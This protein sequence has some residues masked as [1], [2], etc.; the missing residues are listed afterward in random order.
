[1][2]R[3]EAAIFPGQLAE[4]VGMGRTLAATSPAAAAVLA[5][6][7][8][9]LGRQLGA[10]LRRV[11]FEGPPER[12]ATPFFAQTGVVV[13][14]LMSYAA[15]E[16]AEVEVGATAGY[17]LGVLAALAAAEALTLGEVLTV[18]DR[19]IASYDHHLGHFDG[20][21]AAVTGLGEA[22]LRELAALA[23]RPDDSVEIGNFNNGHQFVLTGS[24][25]A[26]LRAIE[27]A[28]PTALGVRLL[29]ITWPVHSVYFEPVAREL[30]AELPAL[31]RP[32]RPR[33][34]VYS[35]ITG[36]PVGD[37]HEVL[38]L[39]ATEIARPVR[40]HQV[41][42]AM[43]RDGHLHF[44]ECGPSSDLARMVRWIDRR[45]VVRSMGEG[46]RHEEVAV[47]GDR[48]GG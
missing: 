23:S 10:E 33:M 1:M 44:T 43:R 11:L 25:A 27:L 41:I 9:E 47:R 39:V 21:M 37:E 17:S 35:P 6:A 32:R 38:E 40:W 26:V 19:Q 16:E 4:R 13:V 46:G 7:E 5:E 29:P 12:L 48:V 18:I 24:R 20:A 34:P 45:A 30:L 31:L 22:A 8:E 15:L 36:E 28:T 14:G 2:R 3:G 42:S